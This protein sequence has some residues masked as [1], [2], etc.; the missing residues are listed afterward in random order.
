MKK[1]IICALGLLIAGCA[2]RVKY[3]KYYALD[4]S[5]TL[6]PSP[7]PTRLPM[8]VSVRRF[9]TPAYLRQGR[10]V[11]REAPEAVDFYE[12]HRWAADPSLTVTAAMMASMRSARLFSFV[13][14][15]DGEDKPD[16]LMT[17]RLD[18]LDEIDYGGAVRVEAKVSAEL[19]DVRSGATVWAG[20]AIATMNVESSN[21]NAVVA[22]MNRALQID[23]EKLVA[24]MRKQLPSSDVATRVAP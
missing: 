5:A 10:I 18:K 9:E 14:P 19:V 3:P 1:I 4:I 6:Q 16:F 15:Y 7:D 17:G 22:A 11:Y 23:I 8:A 21:V 2:G 24:D 20:D 13:K 12:Y